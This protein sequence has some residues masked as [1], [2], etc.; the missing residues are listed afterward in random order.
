MALRI[1]GSL[2]V[3]LLVAFI[4]FTFMSEQ[5]LSIAALMGVVIILWGIHMYTR[6]GAD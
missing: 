1:A 4:V 2:I 6:G 5:L 3:L